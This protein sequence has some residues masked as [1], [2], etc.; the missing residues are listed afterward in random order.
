MF[1]M[2]RKQKGWYFYSFISE[3]YSSTLLK[4]ADTAMSIYFSSKA[5]L[6]SCYCSFEK[7]KSV[8]TAE[9]VWVVYYMR[10]CY[11]RCF[12]FLVFSIL[13][14]EVARYIVRQRVGLHKSTD[15]LSISGTL[16]NCITLEKVKLLFG[17][18]IKNPKPSIKIPIA[19]IHRTSHVYGSKLQ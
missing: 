10:A 7:S 5:V 15:M 4:Y 8:E 13:F 2:K 1:I 16:K 9:R 14:R 17:A 19:S 18:Q 11:I 3:E 12:Y 6:F